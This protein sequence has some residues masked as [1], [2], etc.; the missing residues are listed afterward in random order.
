MKI[1]S[2]GGVISLLDEKES[3]LK[4]FALQRLNQIVDDFWAE[5]S[6]VVDK[7]EVLYE[8]DSFQ[9]RKLAALVASKVYY[10]LGAFEDSLTYALGAGELFDVN[11]SSEYV[12]TTISKCIDFYTKHSV[13]NYENP[14]DKKDI[15][16]RLE[17]VVQRMFERCF[18]DREYK[19]AIGIALETRRID[20]FEKAILQ[21]DSQAE[22]MQYSLKVCLS[23]IQHRQFRNT[24]LR[25]L[26]QLYTSLQV[27]D[28]IN[29]CQCLIFLD[30]PQSV[31]DILGK[32][33]K[34]GHTEEEKSHQ[35]KLE[36]LA[37][38]LSGETSI[39]LKLQ[40]LIR[41]SSKK[42]SLS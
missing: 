16:P 15:D 23:L 4:V 21:S 34:E 14:D 17:D 39:G 27:P 10:H 32:L 25:V 8:D 26:V 30:D 2:A 37:A 19:Q 6:D 13:H 1:T 24:V 22:M 41:R 36:K 33:V 7:I 20:V 9:E 5:I 18:S 28:Y 40:F 42:F 12:E 31:A 11:S 29:V 35:A 38:I 3:D